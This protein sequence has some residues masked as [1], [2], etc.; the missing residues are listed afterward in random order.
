MIRNGLYLISTKFLDGVDG[1]QTGVSV[2][3]DGRML[4]GGSP[5]S[6]WKLSLFRGHVKR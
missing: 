3:R 1:G 4:G 2:L 6:F 5:L